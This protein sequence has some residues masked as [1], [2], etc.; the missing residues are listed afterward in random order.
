MDAVSRRLN[1]EIPGVDHGNAPIP[2]A[3]RV[4]NSFQSSGIMGRDPASNTLPSSGVKQV[5]FVF[6][7][8]RSLC[9]VAGVQLD[10]LVYVEVLLADDQLRS[11]VNKYWTEWY[12]D[13]GDRPARHTTVR[14][15][16]GGMKIQLRL[17]ADMGGMS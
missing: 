15:L 8:A 4:G 11:E 3:A 14:E 6:A 17:Q 1:Y 13:A 7:N 9:Q 5:E 10:Q 12:P 16:P 2:M